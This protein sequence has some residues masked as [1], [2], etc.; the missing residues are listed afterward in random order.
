MDGQAGQ[1]QGWRGNTFCVLSAESFVI[2]RLDRGIQEIYIKDCNNGV[3]LLQS[4]D[5]GFRRYDESLDAAVKPRHDKE[6]K[7][8]CLLR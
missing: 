8:S 5:T 1:S 7:A 2:P 3:P 6:A 4:L